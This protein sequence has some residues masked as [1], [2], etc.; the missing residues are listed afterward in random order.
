MKFK[1][2]VP[3]R[4]IYVS[5]IGFKA[6]DDAK[7]IAII[8]FA[9]N[10]RD[11]GK[12]IYHPDGIENVE[13]YKANP[14]VLLNHDWYNLPIGQSL[15]L[16]ISPERLR[17]KVGFDDDERSVTVYRKLKSRTMR[18]GSIGYDPVVT[19]YDPKL[20]AYHLW[21]TRLYELSVVTIPMN[22]TALVQ[23]VKS[24]GLEMA[25]KGVIPHQKHEMMDVDADWDASAEVKKADVE[26][27]KKMCAF[28]MG[29]GDKKS[30]YK[31]PHHTAEGYK[32]VWKGVAAAMAAVLGARGG[33][34]VPADDRKGVYNHLAKHY[35]EFDKE[36]PDMMKGFDV[37]HPDIQL[38]TFKN[39]ELFHHEIAVIA[40]RLTGFHGDT[41]TVESLIRHHV[42]EGRVLSARN[43]E[44]VDNCI[45][46]LQALL[47]AADGEKS[48]SPDALKALLQ[49]RGNGSHPLAELLSVR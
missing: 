33:V 45:E 39:D 32:T 20:D 22:P 3:F 11:R 28:V 49:H 16:D 5:D 35:E 38:V 46:A 9:T 42:K 4:K 2:S 13:E 25:G 8:D 48:V 40:E 24:L 1:R 27:L 30:D 14:V 12:D 19:E 17:S 6:D 37:R 15:D 21:R 26:D 31:L 43:R 41:K 18:T 10:V 23:F 34:D 29:E 36:P 44:L 7:R 47:Q